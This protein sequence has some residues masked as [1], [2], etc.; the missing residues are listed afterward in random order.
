MSFA[1]PSAE[2]VQ[3]FWNATLPQIYRTLNQME[4]QG[5]LTVKVEPQEGK[6]SR[7]I[8]SITDEGMKELKTGSL[9][10]GDGAGKKPVSY[11]GILWQDGK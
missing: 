1:R 10:T 8:Y 2:S 3:F 6:P 9:T 5:W 4:S 11:Q 7:K